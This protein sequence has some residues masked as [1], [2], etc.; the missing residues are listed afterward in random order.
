MTLDATAKTNADAGKVRILA[1]T[2]AQRDPRLPD[3]PTT[4][5][6]GLRDYVFNSWVGLLAPAATPVA[7]V[8]KLNASLN[9]ALSDPALRRRLQDLGLSPEGGSAPRMQ[10]QVRDDI[11]FHRRIITQAAL[12]FE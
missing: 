11:A 3:V 10:Q 7:T 1:V 8:A 5:E 12:R 6:A 4:T 9:T 2:G